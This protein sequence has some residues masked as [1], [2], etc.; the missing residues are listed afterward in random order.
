MLKKGWITM[1]DLS[2]GVFEIDGFEINSETTPSEIKKRLKERYI[3]HNI[4][5][6]GKSESF[7]FHNVNIN[8]RVF[9]IKLYFYLKSLQNIRLDFMNSECYSFEQLFEQDLLW[10]KAIL[11]EPTESGKFGSIYQYHKYKI[12]VTY[13]PNDGRCGADEFIDIN[14]E[15]G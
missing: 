1:T 8:N 5:P 11:G 10:L 15:R 9:S 7:I 12:G 2:K 13:R 6:S 3:Y 4:T 14:Y